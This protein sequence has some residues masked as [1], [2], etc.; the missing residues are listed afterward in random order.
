MNLWLAETSAAV[1]N[2]ARERERSG[3]RLRILLSYHYYR[4]VDLFDLFGKYFQKPWPDVFLDS[5][6]YSAESQGAVIDIG[7]YAEW[8]KHHASIASAY[9]N[10]DVIG[11]AVGTERNQRELER[12]GLRPLPVFHT[13]EPWSVLERLCDEYPYVALGGMVGKA[14]QRAQLQAWIAKAFGVAGDRTVFHGFGLTVWDLMCAFRWYSVD[15]SSWGSGF[16]FG[17]VQLFDDNAGKFVKVDLRDKQGAWRHRKLIESY[18]FAPSDLAIEGQYDRAAICAMSA[19]A[20]MRADAY[21]RQVHGE[22]V[23]PGQGSFRGNEGVS[24]PIGVTASDGRDDA[25]QSVNEQAEVVSP[26]GGFRRERTALLHR[27][28]QPTTDKTGCSV[29]LADSRGAGERDLASLGCKVHLVCGGGDA[30]TPTMT[31]LN[32]ANHS[33]LR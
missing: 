24:E 12:R 28:C 1:T 22:V 32:D 25:A 19:M 18:G 26:S 23:I 16:R 21:L 11:D 17:T 4:D 7:A 27:R 2:S 20:Y 33:N 3:L 8:V 10:L 6:A 31:G 5:G 30:S 14:K 15:S 9:A 29:Y 13:G